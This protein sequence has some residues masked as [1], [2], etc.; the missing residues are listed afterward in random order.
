MKAG[1]DANSDAQAL[2]DL[3]ARTAGP[4]QG[5]DGLLRKYFVSGAAGGGGVY[6]WR[7]E[8]DARRWFNDDWTRRMLQLYGAVPGV[9]YFAVLACVDNVDGTIRGIT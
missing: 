3:I 6:E 4:Y 2:R 1:A 8:H 5:V 9:E 7:S